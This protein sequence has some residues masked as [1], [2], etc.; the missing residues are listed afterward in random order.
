[1]S[2]EFEITT[3]FSAKYF[4]RQLKIRA[5]SNDF[6][7][8]LILQEMKINRT[9]SIANIHSSRDENKNLNHFQ[10]V[11]CRCKNLTERH[12]LFYNDC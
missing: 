4:V 7:V 10:A 5:H 11:T 2:V 8:P 3:S 9:L 6:E 1:M 12:L